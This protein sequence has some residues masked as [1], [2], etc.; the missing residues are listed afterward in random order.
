MKRTSIFA[1]GAL[2]LASC[3]GND[4]NQDLVLNDLEYFERQGVNVL[5]YSNTPRMKF[6]TA[7]G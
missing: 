5:V 6:S 7:V 4:A 3:G 1:L 2:L